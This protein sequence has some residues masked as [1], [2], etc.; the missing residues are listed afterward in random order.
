MIIGSAVFV[1][2][3]GQFEDIKQRGLA[4]FQNDIASFADFLRDR[5]AELDDWSKI[6]LLT[7][8]INRLHDWC[9]E[10]IA[11]H[12]R[13]CARNVTS[14][15]CRNQPRYSGCSGDCKPARGKTP[16]RPCA[17]LTTCEQCRRAVNGRHV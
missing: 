8:Q 4:Q 13:L 2:P 3:K 1:I 6:K 16:A 15:R 5:V 7:V 10:R 17:P 14:R 11:L 12:R 9:C